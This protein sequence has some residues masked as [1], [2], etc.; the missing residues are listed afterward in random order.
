MC[1]GICFALS[2]NIYRVGQTNVGIL[3]FARHILPDEL[4]ICRLLESFVYLFSLRTRN[5]PVLAFAPP[6]VME[7]RQK[8]L[9]LILILMVFRLI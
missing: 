9:C 5:L 8:M 7:Q 1:V 2:L 4:P 3:A 6:Q